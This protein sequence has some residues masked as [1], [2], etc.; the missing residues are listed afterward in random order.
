LCTSRPNESA[1]DLR[2]VWTLLLLLACHAT[3]YQYLGLQVPHLSRFRAEVVGACV[4]TGEP[5]HH[6]RSSPKHAPTLPAQY[7]APHWTYRACVHMRWHAWKGC[8]CHESSS[9]G[10]FHLASQ[11]SWRCGRGPLP[12]GGWYG[13]PLLVNILHFPSGCHLGCFPHG[14]FSHTLSQAFCTLCFRS[15]FTCPPHPVCI[16]AISWSLRFSR[17]HPQESAMLSPLSLKGT[18]PSFTVGPGG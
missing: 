7:R 4:R 16:F 1:E 13:G 14:P 17:S 11:L 5:E 6:F 15:S 18:P 10:Q 3:H 8:P 12:G 2:P 9:I